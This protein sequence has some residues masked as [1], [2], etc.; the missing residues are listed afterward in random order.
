MILSFAV[1]G[2]SWTSAAV[3]VMNLFFCIIFEMYFS[4]KFPKNTEI[5]GCILCF[6]GVAF[7][8]IEKNLNDKK[9]HEVEEAKA[10][11]Y[12]QLK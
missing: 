9:K 4:R 6:I 2:S 5:I 8:T 1:N 10:A 7:I 11:E 12:I 3:F